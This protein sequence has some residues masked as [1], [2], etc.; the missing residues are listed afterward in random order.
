M[1]MSAAGSMA[2]AVK[3]QIKK[4]NDDIAKIEAAAAKRQA[5]KELADYKANLKEK[6]AELE[7]AE[8]SEKDRIQKEITEL[9][10]EWNEKQLQAQ[11]DAA[12]ELLQT[13]T[14][15]LEKIASE[16][17]STLDGIFD[18]IES[19]AEK[20]GGADLLSETKTGGYQLNT[21]QD[22]I[23][24][25]N[26]YG[27]AIANLKERGISEGLLSEVLEMDMEKATAYSKKLL[28]MSD[29][30][31]Q[32]YM[33]L[34][35]EKEAAAARVAAEIY[36]DDFKE[37]K[38]QYLEQM[39]ELPDEMEEIGVDSMNAMNEALKERGGVAVDTMTS[40]ADR[41][42]SEANRINAAYKMIGAVKSSISSVSS[43]LTSR[44]SENSDRKNAQ[45]NANASRSAAA[46]AV[47]SSGSGQRNIVL[48][49]N[50]KEVARAIVP[51]IRS[52]ES[53]SP[54][55]VNA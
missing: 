14:A 25:I 13:Q 42:V 6:Y 1:A 48:N 39:G 30:Q 24:A 41:I 50:G 32:D 52:V 17:E 31:Y 7:K 38:Q 45:A 12:K 3:N 35:K 51:D 47:A 29:K 40:I 2:S 49:L 26:E 5:D 28:A 34:W 4:L 27:D 53:Q 18:N 43:A 20:I 21:F 9:Q 37:A 8:K 36:A 11:E 33:N 44:S 22:E 16:Y 54:R 46:N 15:A 55:V 10:D 19:T 23:D